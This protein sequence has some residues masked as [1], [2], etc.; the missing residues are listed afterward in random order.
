MMIH[1]TEKI[2]VQKHIKVDESAVIMSVMLSEIMSEIEKRLGSLNGSSRF[3]LR[4]GVLSVH[5]HFV[6]LCLV[7]N[8]K[9]FIKDTFKLVQITGVG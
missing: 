8:I 3:F 9:K 6:V 4:Y 7:Q 1:P 5:H 2:I